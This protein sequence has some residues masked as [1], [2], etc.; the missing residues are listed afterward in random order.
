[1]S[2]ITTALEALRAGKMI[3][4]VD[5]ENRENEGD[6]VMAAE[7]MT[8]EA[9]NFMIREA[10]GLLCLPLDSAGIDRLGLA[11]MV[12][13]NT[14][15]Y[16]TAF[17]VSIGAR[18]G[19]TTG[20]S[21]QDRARTIRVA[22]DPHS[23]P[24]D[25]SSPGHIFPLCAKEGGVLA[26]NGHT[27]GAVDLMRLAGLT[28]AAAICEIINEDGSMARLPELRL[29]AERHGLLIVTIEE[30][31]TYRLTHETLIDEVSVTRLPSTYTSEPLELH[32]FRSRIKG[33]EYVALVKGPL[34][35]APLVRVHSGCL[36]GD[37]LGSLR[38]DCGAQLQTALRLISEAPS[39]ALIYMPEH[40]GR[41]IGLANKI[42]AYAL[43]DEGMDTVEANHALGFAADLREYGM[44][45]QILR[46]LG[47]SGMRLLTNS[48]HKKE[49]LQK[50][51]FDN[52]EQVPLIMQPNPYN[53]AYL[54]TKQ[55]KLDHYLDIS[56]ARDVA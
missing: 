2:R 44:A 32:A 45:A 11:P 46:K 23:G 12:A 40:E 1:M 50:Y 18:T 36:T 49:A 51:G 16:G 53:L 55:H 30:L 8:Q 27:E 33:A 47:V 24:H 6:L 39:G 52:I 28:P 29:F 17:T 54:A 35:G 13:R 19:V 31:I 14:A 22:A 34:Q 4:L 42:K 15:R 7:F 3:V 43:Q 41:G 20:I 56:P 48:R 5:N 9:V 25:I 26:R 10:R 38:C 37:V 21:A